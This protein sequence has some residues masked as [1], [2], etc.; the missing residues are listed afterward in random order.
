MDI[1]SF[2]SIM[3]VRINDVAVDPLTFESRG[4]KSC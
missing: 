4:Y 2:A 1:K 3:R